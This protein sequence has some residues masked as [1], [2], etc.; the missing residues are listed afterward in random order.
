MLYRLK[1]QIPKLARLSPRLQF[2]LDRLKQ[3]IPRLANS[4]A[5]T[6]GAIDV[7]LTWQHTTNIISSF[8]AQVHGE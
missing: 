3:Q 5:P 8:P 6:E 4:Q 2:M 1:Q 7:L